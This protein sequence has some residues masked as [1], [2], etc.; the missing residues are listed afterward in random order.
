MY[1]PV[2]WSEASAVGGQ[3]L[4][5]RHPSDLPGRTHQ[6]HGPVEPA[7]PVEAAP[8]DEVHGTDVG[9]GRWGCCWDGQG[10][11]KSSM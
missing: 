8:G 5:G 9:D 10:R 1:H 3:R 4:A 6:R 7:A 2:G 11:E